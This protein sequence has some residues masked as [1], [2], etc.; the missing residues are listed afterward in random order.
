MFPPPRVLHMERD[1]EG[2]EDQ[3]ADVRVVMCTH[4]LDL[5]M[6]QSMRTRGCVQ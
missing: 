6:S 5:T 2:L 3:T 1:R 4:S